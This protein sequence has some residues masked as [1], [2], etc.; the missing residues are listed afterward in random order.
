M[1]R[2]SVIIVIFFFIVTILLLV[3]WLLLLLAVTV[4][5]SS[6]LFF[7]FFNWCGWDQEGECFLGVCAGHYS[8]ARGI[9]KQRTCLYFFYF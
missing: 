9:I 7:F 1:K 5:F 4:S 2:T 8:S 3:T 6:S